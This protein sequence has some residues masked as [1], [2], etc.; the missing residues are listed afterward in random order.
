[1]HLVEVFDDG[2]VGELRGVKDDLA[3]F[4]V[5]Q[6]LVVDL[7][8]PQTVYTHVLSAHYTQPCM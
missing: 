4:G 6:V 5:F 2:A 1:M 8:S 3:C 7:N